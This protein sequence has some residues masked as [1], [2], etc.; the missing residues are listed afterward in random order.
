MDV[1]IVIP[2][3]NGGDLLDNVLSAVFSQKTEYSYEVICVDS[4][5]KDQTLEIIKKYD[6]R[7]YQIP[8]SEFGHGKTRNYGAF[9][10][11]GTYIV[12]LTQDAL[13]ASDTW[14]QNFMDAMKL[15][16]DIVGGFGIH[17]PYEDCNIF[18]KRDLD[19][20]FKGFGLDNTIYWLEDREKYEKEEAYRHKL[21]FFSDN[22]S[23]VRR[24]I[25]E[26]YPYD[27]VNF[28]EDQLWAIKMIEMGY[29]K[30]Y[31]PFAPVYHSHNYP[32]GTYFSRYYDEY[33]GLYQLHKYKLVDTWYHLPRFI[34]NHIRGDYHYLK[35]ITLP[36]KEKVRWLIYSIR[37]NHCR[38]LGGYL[39][40]R[41]T[42]WSPK[43]QQ[44]M[45]RLIS[46]Q[47]KQR[48]A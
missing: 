36:R 46:Q 15:D 39:A 28:A 19:G 1:T 14:L 4:G 45:D 9:K 6:C 42:D 31:C 10:G 34:W 22:N 44:R 23:C 43:K 8:P 48:H 12:F 25:F 7:L 35:S 38:Y 30:I 21:A 37:K 27:D 3:K 26:K 5:S 29:K 13:P 17:Y 40:G 16:P 47:Y 24:D 2:T 33:K 32:I 11:T 20:H 18:E 41:Y